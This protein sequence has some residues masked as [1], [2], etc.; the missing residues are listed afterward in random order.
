MTTRQ[1]LRPLP[2]VFES[3]RLPA[4]EIYSNSFCP[5]HCPRCDK[6]P[7]RDAFPEF[8]FTP[9]M[10]RRLAETLEKHDCEIDSLFFVGGE[11]LLWEHWEECAVILKETGRVRSLKT[12]TALLDGIDMK[13]YEAIFDLIAV[14]SY[15]S[16]RHLVEKYAVGNP[17]Y[18]IFGREQHHFHPRGRIPGTV[19]GHCYCWNTWLFDDRVYFCP[20]TCSILM[21]GIELKMSR[22]EIAS[23]SWSLDEFFRNPNIYHTGFGSRGIC[24]GCHVNSNVRAIVGEAAVDERDVHGAAVYEIR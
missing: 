16:N 5:R 7:V 20:V 11:P 18:A 4:L 9:E 8:Q 23:Y 17:R 12:T 15:G 10:A 3:K 24:E 22:E 19:P 13:P 14:S 6:G 1:P 21:S 2:P